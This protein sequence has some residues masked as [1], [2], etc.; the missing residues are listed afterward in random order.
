VRVKAD[1]VL[2][3]AG[4]T[5]MGWGQR[6]YDNWLRGIPYQSNDETHLHFAL[7]DLPALDSETTFLDPFGVYS[8]LAAYPA[9]DTDWST[10]LGSLWL[11]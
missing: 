5:G 8:G 2:G 4:I 6:T 3:Y 10:L 11:K 9:Y 7:S 1:Q